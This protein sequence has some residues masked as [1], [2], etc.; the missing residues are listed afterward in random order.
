MSGHLLWMVV[1]ATLISVFLAVLWRREA[2]DRVRF[3][4]K[5]WSILIFGGIAFAWLMYWLPGGSAITFP[6]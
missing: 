5:V 1:H 6:G 2:G 3:F 4:A